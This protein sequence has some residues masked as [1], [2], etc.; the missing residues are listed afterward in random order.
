MRKAIPKNIRQQVYEKYNGHCA[1]CGCELEY[2]DMQVDHVDS[3]YR[4]EYNHRDVDDTVNNYMPACRSC[5]FYKSVYS[6][7]QFRNNI[8]TM[9]IG[10]LHKDF[11]YK[12]L[13]KYG[14]VREE[15]K[16]VK[17]YF[18]KQG[19]YNCEMIAEMGDDPGSMIT[20]DG[21][22]TGYQISSENN[23]PAHE[24]RGCKY[25]LF[26]KENTND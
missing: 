2:K 23:I 25:S 21:K 13:V 6:I 26:Y 7:E 22:C 12:M 5:N 11:N 15:F 10:K 14:M 3:V 1:Y 24:C 16:P 17:F 19:V 8:E 20:S 9:L 18:E 4:A